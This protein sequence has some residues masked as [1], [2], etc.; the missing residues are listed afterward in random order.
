MSSGNRG[1]RRTISGKVVCSSSAEM[2]IQSRRLIPSAVFKS[3]AACRYSAASPSVKFR[4]SPSGAR[5]MDSAKCRAWVF[6]NLP[7]YP[8]ALR[9]MATN[10]VSLALYTPNSVSVRLSAMP[11]R[12]AHDTCSVNASGTSENAPMTA[13]AVEWTSLPSSV[14]RFSSS[15]CATFS[16]KAFHSSSTA[17]SR[18]NCSAVSGCGV[19]NRSSR[20]PYTARRA[21]ARSPKVYG[22]MDS[23]S[24]LSME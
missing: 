15:F 14:L 24:R 16:A 3:I 19:R 8:M 17:S 20:M 23:F 13:L 7:R 6:S 1:V 9:S 18:E 12:Y 2:F 10:A 5:P 21:T 11:F 4:D 22:R